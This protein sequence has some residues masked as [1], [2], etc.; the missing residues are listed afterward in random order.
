M[1]ILALSGS[2]REASL[3]TLLLRATARLAPPEITVTV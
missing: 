3:N 1:N 2:L